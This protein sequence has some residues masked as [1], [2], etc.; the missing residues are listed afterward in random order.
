MTS[1]KKCK[2]YSNH[3]VTDQKLKTLFII[4]CKTSRVFRGVQ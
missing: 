3:D 2:T 1:T 4:K